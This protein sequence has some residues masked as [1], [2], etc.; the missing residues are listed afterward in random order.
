[1]KSGSIMFLLSTNQE[2]W[3]IQNLVPKRRVTDKLISLQQEIK[4]NRVLHN[5]V[6]N[7]FLFIY[8]SHIMYNVVLCSWSKW[9]LFNKWGEMTYQIYVFLIQKSRIYKRQVLAS[10]N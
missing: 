4:L 7:L 5:N 6:F 9:P 3:Y 10:L 1:M 8:V 2:I